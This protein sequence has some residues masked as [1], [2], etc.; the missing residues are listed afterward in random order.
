MPK[1]Q[2]YVFNAYVSCVVALF[3][4]HENLCFLALAFVCM[5]THTTCDIEGI[6]VQTIVTVATCDGTRLYILCVEEQR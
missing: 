6:R 4:Y 5:P 3:A 1:V 2:L